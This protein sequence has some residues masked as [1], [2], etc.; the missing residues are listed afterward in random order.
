MG[1]NSFRILFP[2]VK[3]LGYSLFGSLSETLRGS[4]SRQLSQRQVTLLRRFQRFFFCA[5]E[6]AKVVGRLETPQ[7]PR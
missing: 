6:T 5:R 7:V 3:T 4:F 2:S 1:L